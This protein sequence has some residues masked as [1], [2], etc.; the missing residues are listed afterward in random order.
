MKEQMQCL[1]TLA[2]GGKC[3]LTNRSMSTITPLAP[4]LP[5][6]KMM[7]DVDDRPVY[8]KNMGGVGG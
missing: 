3:S 2:P 4:A 1:I 6:E 8:C 5:P 7:V